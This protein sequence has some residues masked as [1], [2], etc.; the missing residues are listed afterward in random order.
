[1]F[2]DETFHRQNDMKTIVWTQYF[3]CVFSEMKT[4]TS[5]NASVGRGLRI[6]YQCFRI[7]CCVYTKYCDLCFDFDIFVIVM[8]TRSAR[9]KQVFRVKLLCSICKFGQKEVT[10]YGSSCTFETTDS[11]LS[12]SCW[13]NWTRSSTKKF[14][15]EGLFSESISFATFGCC[16]NKHYFDLLND[17]IYHGQVFVTYSISGENSLAGSGAMVTLWQLTSQVLKVEICA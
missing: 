1:M 11:I 15:N 16:V 8:I 5:E 14:A 6:N 2:Q 17:S 13:E 3:H 10:R 7:D 4:Q 9:I 12:V